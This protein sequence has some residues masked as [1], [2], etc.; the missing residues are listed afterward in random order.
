MLNDTRDASQWVQNEEDKRT[1]NC[2]NIQAVAGLVMYEQNTMQQS[3][4]TF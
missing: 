1:S 4:K 2:A 3:F